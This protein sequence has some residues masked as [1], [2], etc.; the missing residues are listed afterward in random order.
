M[1]HYI[2]PQY[3]DPFHGQTLIEFCPTSERIITYIIGAIIILGA[4][5]SIMTLISVYF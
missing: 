2:T 1:L 4:L 5:I 3:L